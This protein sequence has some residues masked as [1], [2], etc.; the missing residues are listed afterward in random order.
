MK[1]LYCLILFILFNLSF[2]QKLLIPMDSAQTDHLKAYGIA[3]L[4]LKNL[5]NV[6]WLLNYRGGSFLM[7]D[8]SD[9]QTICKI[10]GVNFEL[11]DSWKLSDMLTTI[12]L[13]LNMI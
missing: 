9:L 8:L 1:K 7:D 2:S 13:I 5:N 3:F 10:R 4:Q 12:E 6:E 11:I